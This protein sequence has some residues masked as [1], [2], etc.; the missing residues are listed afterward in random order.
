MWTGVTPF[1]DSD[2]MSLHRLPPPPDWLEEILKLVEPER[3]ARLIKMQA[4]VRAEGGCG[5]LQ[6]ASGL[7][8]RR[9]PKVGYPVCRKH[10]ERAPQTV[11]KAERLLA[12]AR[13]PAIELLLDELD[14]YQEVTCPTCGYPSHSIKER[15]HIAGIAFKMLDR[16]GFGPR[17]TVDLNARAISEK[18][19]EVSQMSSE[20]LAELEQLLAALEALKTRHLSRLAAEQAREVLAPEPQRLLQSDVAPAVVARS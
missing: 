7:P 9:P 1:G 6:T 17:S 20:E 12:V 13:M 5:S 11:A 10:G 16:T 19:V 18:T 2:P 8:C 3:Q 14:Q 4:L 15:K